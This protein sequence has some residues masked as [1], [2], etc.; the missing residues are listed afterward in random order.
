MVAFTQGAL[1]LSRFP[2]RPFLRLALIGAFV[3][4]FALVGCGRKGGLD[5]P[6]AA[7]VAGEQQAAP[8]NAEKPTIGPNGQP[9]A[10][11]GEKKRIPLDALLN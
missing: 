9:E 6:P 2:D 8:S 5:P 10:P 7:S 4:A 11:K 3:A 1:L